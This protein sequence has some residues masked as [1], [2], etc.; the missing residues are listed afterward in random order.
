MDKWRQ[1]EDALSGVFGHAKAVADGHEVTLQKALSN[2]RLVVLVYVD[3]WIKGE[4][5][6]ADPATGQPV[7]PQAR[8]WRPSRS[9]VFPLK[10]YKALKRALG[11][12]RAD[13]MTA[14]KVVCFVPSWNSPRSLV[15]HLKK[16]FPD[17]EL[18]DHA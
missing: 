11:K 13:E 6:E 10:Q 18:K 12:K 8:F 2:E 14:R 15:R 3:G 17:L 16:Y 1:L 7:H 9:R 4:W 5:W